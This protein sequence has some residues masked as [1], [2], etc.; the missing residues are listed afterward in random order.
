MGNPT[1]GKQKRGRTGNYLL[2]FLLVVV[3]LI[4]LTALAL[5]IYLASPLPARQ[6]SRI[7]TAYLHQNLSVEH[8]QTSGGALYLRG[9]RLDN[10]P[11]YSKGSLATADSIVIAPHWGD[12]LLGRQRFRVVTLDGIKVALEKNSKGEWNFAPLQQLLAARKP[13]P[14]E[15]FIKQFTLKDGAV[16]L[17]G[18]GVQGIAL[19]IF[20]LTT[21]GS[22]DSKIDLSFE[23]LAH[24]RFTLTGKGRAGTEPAV[25]LNLSAPSLS[26]KEVATLLKLKNAAPFEGGIGSLQV[27][28]VFQKGEFSTAGNFRFSQLR[29]SAASKSYPLDG[30]FAFAA[31][32]SLSRDVFQLKSCLLK[33]NNLVQM[34]AV[35]TVQK[36]KKERDFTLDLGFN[37]VDLG[38]LAALIPEQFRKNLAFGGR[39]GCQ[40]L[41]LAGNGSRVTN[42]TGTLRLRD[43]MLVRDGHLYIAGMTGTIGFSRT[44]A[45]ILA[46]GRLSLSGPHEKALLESLDMPFSLRVSRQMQPL[47][48]EIHSFSAQIMGISCT[49]R[50]AYDAAKRDSLTASLKVPASR[51]TT[52]KPLW[53]RYGLIANSGTASIALDASGKSPQQLAATVEV[54]LADFQGSRGGNAL[55]LKNGVVS[56][57]LRRGEGHLLMQGDASLQGLAVKGQGG[58]A[59]FHY[60]VVDQMAYLEGTEVSAAGVQLSV[61][62]LS[63]ALPEKK[64]AAKATPLP[65]SLDFDGCTVKRGELEVASLRGSLRALLHTD[66][67]EKWLEGRT[68]LASG[69]VSWQGKAVAAPSA[70]LAL[71]RSGARGELR[72]TLLG[73]ALGGTVSGNPFAPQAG[74]SFDL[75]L[76]GAEVTAI[77]PLLPKR[78]GGT[79]TG[80]TL[81][82]LR[83]TGSFS[84]A[85]GLS[86]RFESQASRIALTGAG[87]RALVSG[88]AFNLAG[89]LAGGKLSI[90]DAMLSP[91]QGVAL[92]FKGALVQ[93]FSAQRS[94]SLTFT[95][96]ETA[97]KSLVTP[98]INLLPRVI[99][100]A[101][102]DGTLAAD[103]KLYLAQGKELVE[104]S[105]AIKGG[106]FEL[107]QQKLL[108]SGIDGRFPFSLDLSGQPGPKPAEVMPF[109][110]GNY[111]KLLTELRRVSPGA[112]ILKVGKMS[113]GPMEL[114][115][116]TIHASAAN[117]MTQITSLNSTLY[118]G[119]LFGRGFLTMRKG[120]Q[121]RGDLL[122]HDLS[123]KQFCSIFPGIKGYISGRVDGVVSLSGGSKGLAGLTGFTEIWAH[124]GSG[125][126]MLVSKEFLQRLAKQKLSG[127]FFRS[128]RSYDQAEIKALMESGYLSFQT[129]QLVHTNFFGVR[130]LNVSIAPTQNR[131]AL[132]HLFD[133]IKQ[134]AVRGKPTSK[135]PQPAEEKAPAEAPAGPEFKWGE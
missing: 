63:A 84:R 9:V 102:F 10:P 67:A 47:R 17:N 42:A 88:A 68:D 112:E 76:K 97:A 29:Y 65:I 40:A 86:C 122:V 118:N 57:K 133:S 35:G 99:Q 98:L 22:R 25:D 41:H 134:A 70:Q 104:G 53:E 1:E 106:R 101:T 36:M 121:Y 100:E 64:G 123:L 28:T 26:L 14:T 74:A 73:G 80:G 81:D 30:N 60:R 113:F 132:D 83:V 71:S 55:A 6:V 66:S 12:L 46:Q 72:G 33:V 19:Q 77:A 105:L 82:G 38:T 111:P 129:L 96:P 23:D 127:F 120:F 11:G 44:G 114:G 79:L 135:E 45:G 37:D 108:V 27:N 7:L 103:G 43:G 109:S 116:L 21:K 49:G 69:R 34:H 91:G 32:Y 59:R 125:E 107:S 50:F 48:A 94:G 115:T 5:G 95:L 93:P 128:D 15:T 18:Q 126:K 110:R 13:S 75:G 56:A 20:N 61:A 39:L 52:L 119:E 87:G 130:D 51:V 62:H 131:I 58:D 8:L 3:C 24:N 2:R 85:A 92:R 90:S 54:R 31:D 78:S 16:T 117:G 124:E 89:D 4:A